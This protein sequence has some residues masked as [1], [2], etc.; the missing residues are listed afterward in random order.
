LRRSASSW[1]KEL[2]GTA[3]DTFIHNT[4]AEIHQG[5]L[6]GEEVTEEEARRE[7][8]VEIEEMIQDDDENFPL[9]GVQNGHRPDCDFSMFYPGY[10][11]FQE[12]SGNQ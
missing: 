6:D 5:A 7:S 11:R 2:P 4:L 1:T 10:T 9:R 8:I 3:R 12:Q